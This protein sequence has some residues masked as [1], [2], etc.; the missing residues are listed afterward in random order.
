[1][2]NWELVASEELWGLT[3]FKDILERD[4]SEDKE[5]AMKELLYIFFSSDIKSDYLSILSS[6]ERTNEIKK[7]ISLPA[8]WEPDPLVLSAMDMYEKLSSSVI[9]KL[10]KQ[11]L[12]AASDIGDYLENTKALLAERDVNGKP[13]YDIA[14]ITAAIQKVP[15][16]M[17]DL[18]S[19][20]KE[21]VKEQED[22][23]NKKKG[24]QTMN[25]FE[26]MKGIL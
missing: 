7:D 2:K 24:S 8:D 15:K 6:T 10:Y 17:Q 16:L 13:V 18:N 21:V 5:L 25:T 23:S 11:T 9:Q 20:Y 14:K 19:A 4:E 26:N 3:P 12:K 22:L 1:M